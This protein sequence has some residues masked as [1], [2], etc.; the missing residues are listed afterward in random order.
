M[1]IQER[2]LTKQ[3]V[4][5]YTNLSTLAINNAIRS[6]ELKFAFVN[7]KHLFKIEWVDNWLI[8]K[9]GR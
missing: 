8:T 7:N 3:E 4:K 9:G 6:G 1:E 2:Y 5:E